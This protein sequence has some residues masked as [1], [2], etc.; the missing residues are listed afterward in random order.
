M[1]LLISLH[2]LLPEMTLQHNVSGLCDQLAKLSLFIWLVV[3]K[4]I[5]LP[6]PTWPVLLRTLQNGIC[7]SYACKCT[8]H[9]HSCSMCMEAD[10]AGQHYFICER[11][12]YFI[13]LQSLGRIQTFYLVHIWEYIKAT[14]SHFKC[15]QIVYLICSLHNSEYECLGCG[16]LIDLR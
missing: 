10:R 11:T 8:A 1:P 16:V 4:G 3:L 6:F 12:F 7:C 15:K 13:F 14:K 2:H 5:F 9:A